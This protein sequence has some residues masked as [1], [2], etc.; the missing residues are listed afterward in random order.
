MGGIFMVQ[1]MAET[2][3]VGLS[4]CF[5]NDLRARGIGY[6][7]GAAEGNNMPQVGTGNDYK[8]WEFY[9]GFAELQSQTVW[10]LWF[11]ENC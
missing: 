4:H 2:E 6:V 10:F 11:W 9:R 7:D 3:T 8:G 1:Q 5:H